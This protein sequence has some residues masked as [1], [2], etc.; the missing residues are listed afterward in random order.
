[1]GAGWRAWLVQHRAH[2]AALTAPGVLIAAVLADPAQPWWRYVGFGA[3]ALAC[4]ASGFMV[5][6]L[7]DLPW[8]RADPSKGHFPLVD[9]RIRERDA[10]L[11]ALLVSYSAFAVGAL[12]ALGS[13]RAPWALLAFL[14]F[15]VF[16]SLYNHRAKVSLWGP[17][18]IS[19]SFAC[20]PL[21]SWLAS[22][23][24][25]A[26]E[27]AYV[28][29]YGL[30]M[31]AAQIA[32]SGYAKEL[33]Q[34]GEVNLLRTL[35]ASAT[36]TSEPGAFDYRFSGRSLAWSVGLR[37][38]LVLGAV[39]WGAWRAADIGFLAVFAA[40]ALF[41][42]AILLQSGTHARRTKVGAMAAAEVFAYLLLVASLGMDLG[43]SWT[44]G[45]L[46]LPILWFVSM[47]R[48]MF[49]RALAPAV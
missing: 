37:A 23:G 18:W 20:L 3:V 44:Y 35:G 11:A 10:W 39:A 27:I 7:L 41:A 26:P 38:P 36:P 46:V 24:G 25:W 12:L 30:L 13:P 15:A 8:D 4:H 2:T 34:D 17:L 1:M 32:V 48:V 45:L 9:G 16:G 40:G 33:G 19:L 22:G 49:G 31:M 21:W 5:N 14:G 42:W 47:N 6:G 29:G 28:A 43:P